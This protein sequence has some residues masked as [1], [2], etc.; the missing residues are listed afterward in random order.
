MGI[1]VKPTNEN[2]ERVFN[3]IDGKRFIVSSLNK[4][5]GVR[6]VYDSAN[7]D[8]KRGYGL[9]KDTK[10]IDHDGNTFIIIDNNGSKSIATMYRP[11]EQE[12][13]P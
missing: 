12:Y 4:K 3:T 10:S 13:T 6:D 9:N 5:T 1:I 7:P 2:G 8:E 11:T